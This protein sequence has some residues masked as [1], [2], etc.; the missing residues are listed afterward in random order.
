VKADKEEEPHGMVADDSHPSS[1]QSMG[2]EKAGYRGNQPSGFRA[3]FPFLIFSQGL[4]SI[5]EAT[6]P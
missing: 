3:S 2:C 4:G 6:V 1:I 5:N